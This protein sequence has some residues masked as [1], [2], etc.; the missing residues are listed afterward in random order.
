MGQACWPTPNPGC[1]ISA[2]WDFR[3]LAEDSSPEVGRALSDTGAGVRL[4][5]PESVARPERSC[6]G[7]R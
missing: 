6:G 7:S 5:V 1:K 3:P 4:P 2:L